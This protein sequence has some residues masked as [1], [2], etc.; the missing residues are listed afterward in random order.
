M[1]HERPLSGAELSCNFDGHDTDDNRPALSGTLEATVNSATR[2]VRRRR[3]NPHR[4]GVDPRSYR[5]VWCVI[6]SAT[7]SNNPI[8]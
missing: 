6:A 2:G 1:M 7:A 5:T 8:R 3:S 4:F